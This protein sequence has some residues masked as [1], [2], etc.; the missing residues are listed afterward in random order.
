MARGLAVSFT[1]AALAGSVGSDAPWSE[2]LS[3]Q[4]PSCV[5]RTASGDLEGVLRGGTCVY[6]GVP[7]AAPPVAALR[8][9]PPQP[10]IPW[11]P[12]VLNAT[13]TAPA[14]PQINPAGAMVGVEDCLTLNVWVPANPTTT[15]R[16]PVLIWLH[17]GSFLGASS[18]LAASDGR[19]FAEERGAIVVAPNYRLG[20]FGFL[21]HPAL[22]MEDPNY[23]SSGNY[24]LADQRAAIRWVRQNIEGFGGNPGLVTLAGTSAGAISVSA[25]LVSPASQGLFQRA[26]MQSGNA[27]AR[28]ST[29]IDGELQGHAFAEAL[30]CP[31]GP[32][33]L[34][35]LRSK[36]RDEVLSALPLSTLT[37]GFQQFT[38][39]PGRVV[40]GPIVDG[41]E[42]PDQPRD[43][44][45]RA[46][47]SRVPIIIGTNAD[48]GWTFADRS[49]PT[50]L[51]VL[52]Y[53]RTVRTE[54]GMDANAVLDLY[55]VH[56]FPTPK[57]AL[58]R[59]TS[60][61][62]FVCEARR[63][64]NAMHHDGAPVFLY[65]FEYP[66]DA[67]SQGRVP[68]GLETNLL[69]GNNFG[70]P[71]NHVLTT[72]DLEIFQAMSTYWRRFME[73]GD[74][75]PRGRPVQWP[76]YRPD[77]SRPEDDQSFNDYYFEFSRNRS[78]RQFLRD[79][80]CNFWERF[81]FRS[82]LGAVPAAA[83]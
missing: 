25:H 69:F 46:D 13:G 68:H 43:L 18:S 40:W 53:E 49:F 31:N 34:A 61:V 66:V 67:V 75:N 8:W 5:A 6:L 21:A 28:L 3:A 79:S 10:R 2:P 27:T 9:K 59:L 74:P 36:S 33:V 51:D 26:I 47:F 80:P 71:S 50:G 38:Q 24:G 63:I 7:Y 56:R 29:H 72:A 17:P 14:C 41:V 16:P 77:R 70:A 45:R 78:I 1:V 12:A 4:T 55:P 60:D 11:A 83:R 57:D 62:E 30:S 81:Y 52:G 20:A 23:P 35:C 82:V 76:S 19:R 22:A 42:I 73:N 64:A 15:E 32:G 58:A 44:Y 48:E 37:G 39:E 65:S 54:F